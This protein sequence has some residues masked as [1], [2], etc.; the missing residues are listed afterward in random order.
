ME[1]EE[2]TPEDDTL[3]KEGMSWKSIE[4]LCWY[5]VL[6]AISNR[7]FGFRGLQ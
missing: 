2:E 4:L 7:K 5:R 1:S 3:K 6:L